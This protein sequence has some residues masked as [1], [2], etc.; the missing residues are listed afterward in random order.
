[1]F[2]KYYAKIGI[3]AI[4]YNTKMEVSIYIK[5]NTEEQNRIFEKDFRLS[6][7]LT[8]EQK[9]AIENRME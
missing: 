6:Q 5:A 9:Y 3:T 1:M 4:A 7:A 2:D 8:S